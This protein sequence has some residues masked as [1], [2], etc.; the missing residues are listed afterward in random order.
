MEFLRRP[1]DMIFVALPS[2]LQRDDTGKVR[3]R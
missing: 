2:D 1:D 3:T